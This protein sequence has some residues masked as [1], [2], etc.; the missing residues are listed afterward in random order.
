MADL[1]QTR[2][3]KLLRRTANIVGT[4]AIVTETLQEVFPVF[5]LEDAPAELQIL[6]G[7]RLCFGGGTVTP[8][9]GEAG[10]FQIFNP[11]GSGHIITVTSFNFSTITTSTMRY[12]I[13]NQAIAA[14]ATQR[15]A[16]T[17]GVFTGLPVGSFNQV[18]SVALA[19]ATGQSRILGSTPYILKD[20]KGL[21]VL[22]PGTGLEVG[23]NGTNII[24]F[25]TFHWR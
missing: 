10:R 20:R 9:V 7:T 18:S 23:S 8:P 15:F 14:V 13:T 11:A 19:P 24:V 12:G 16:D 2:W 1:Q 3:D 5:D 4:G 6:G 21:F 17:R 25:C 22:A